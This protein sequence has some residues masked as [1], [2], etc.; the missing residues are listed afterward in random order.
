MR[1]NPPQGGGGTPGTELEHAFRR[2]Q[3]LGHFLEEFA[4]QRR[5]DPSGDRRVVRD[6]LVFRDDSLE[7]SLKRAGCVS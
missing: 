1:R 5:E 3:N 2:G 6:A 7:L 4:A